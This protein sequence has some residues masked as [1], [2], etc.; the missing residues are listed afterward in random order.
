MPSHLAHTVFA[1]QVFVDAG[2]LDPAEKTPPFAV[3][4]AQGPDLFYHNRRSKPS[5]L[6]YGGLLH[7]KGYGSFLGNAAAYL[8]RHEGGGTRAPAFRYVAAAASHAILDRAAHPYINYFAGWH[9][10]GGDEILRFTHAFLERLIDVAV[11]RRFWNSSPAE[12]DF[13][14]M[15][16]LGP[17]L[18]E[19]LE[20][21]IRFGL[22]ST[23]PRAGRDPKL[24]RRM[25]NAYADAM[26]FYRFTNM[27]DAEALRR[28]IL[29]GEFRRRALTIVHPPR[30]PVDIDFLNEERRE[31]LHPCDESIRSRETFWD[32][33]AA[34][35]TRAG[36]VL[37]RTAKAWSDPTA[38]RTDVLARTVR[39]EVSDYNL[40]DGLYENA[41]CRRVYSEP[42]PLSR[43]IDE[44]YE[45]LG[46]VTSG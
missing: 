45:E 19:G 38:E 31:W 4:G 14:G 22:R 23:F 7:R 6:H 41:T 27:I 32:V 2:L 21:A 17:A 35:R 43:F 3:F 33:Y 46:Q 10:P 15:I 5:G 13:A 11:I 42:L 34:A 8:K 30:L 29:A 28:R 12:L 44:L 20:R 1:Q 36:E 26:G 9:R 25:A 40:T 37:R 18:P 39:D 16:D 24:P